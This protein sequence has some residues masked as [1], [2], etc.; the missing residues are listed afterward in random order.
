MFFVTVNLAPVRNCL[1]TI[2]LVVPAGTARVISGLLM[3]FIVPAFIAVSLV[4][5]TA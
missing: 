4:V 3:S 5:S 1:A 2:S